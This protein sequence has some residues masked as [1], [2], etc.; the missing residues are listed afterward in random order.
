[1]AITTLNNLSINRSDTAAADNV[2]TAT[3]ATAT[4]FQ[5]AAGGAWSYITTVTVS[6]ENDLPLIDGTAGV[7]LDS[8]YIAYHLWGFEIMAE[9]NDRKPMLQISTDTGS[10][11]ETSGYDSYGIRVYTGSTGATTST[12]DMGGFDA[13][14]TVGGELLSINVFIYNPSSTNNFPNVNY[15]AIWSNAQNAT[16]FQAG[17][18]RFETVGSWDGI[19]FISNVGNITGTCKLYGLT[20]S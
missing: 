10:S 9:D 5:A 12:I 15:Q 2:W 4:D 6:D 7:I 8:T 13:T 20:G 19:R 11:W 14:G 3:S 17:G 1:M 16:M 18:G